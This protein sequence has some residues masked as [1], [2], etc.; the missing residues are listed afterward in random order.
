MTHS[1]GKERWVWL[2]REWLKL[3]ENRMRQKLLP[4]SHGS[5]LATGKDSVFKLRAL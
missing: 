3:A 2:S 5:S 1:E 4:E